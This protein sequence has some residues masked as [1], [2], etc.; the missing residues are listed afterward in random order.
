MTTDFI[1]QMQAQVQKLLQPSA[2]LINEWKGYW[3]YTVRIISGNFSICHCVAILAVSYKKFDNSIS[4]HVF[5]NHQW[6]GSRH[7]GIEVWCTDP[8]V[9]VDAN[10][11][12]FLADLPEF[13][14][15]FFGPNVWSKQDNA[16]R[17]LAE[18]EWKSQTGCRV[19]KNYIEEEGDRAVT[20]AACFPHDL[21]HKSADM[22]TFFRRFASLS[23]LLVGD[24]GKRVHFCALSPSQV[25]VI[26]PRE[27]DNEFC[28]LFGLSE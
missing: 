14:A 3:N 23:R 15:T 11:S 1:L 9:D 21:L 2:R 22:E 13:V 24:L 8:S 19:F 25:C 12:L 4:L 10:L 18:A 7:H 17:L 5:N 27:L 6:N 28:K 20:Y 16:E 26:I